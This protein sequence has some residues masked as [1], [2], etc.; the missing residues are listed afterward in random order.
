MIHIL[1]LE[2][3]PADAELIHARLEEEGI[4]FQSTRVDREAD[5]LGELNQDHYQVILSDYNV[6][7]ADPIGLLEQVRTQKP[8][9]PFIFV[10]GTIGEE[11]AVEVLR[12]GATDYVLKDNPTRLGTAVRRALVS[13]EE[14]VRRAQ[15]EAALRASEIRF[16]A[17]MDHNPSLTLIKDSAGR[18]LFSNGAHRKFMGIGEH[19]ILGRTIH[20]FFDAAT[21]ARIAEQDRWVFENNKVLETLMSVPDKDG[22]VR[23]LLTVKFPL[24]SSSGEPLLGGLLVDVTA[25]RSAEQ[26]IR[27][28]AGLLNEAHD[29]ICVCTTD[30]HIQYWNRS[31]SRIFGLPEDEALSQRLDAVLV[32]KVPAVLEQARHALLEQ[33]CWEGD[34]QTAHRDGTPVVVFSRWTLVRDEAGQP[35]SVLLINSDVTETRKLE[36]QF[37]RAQRVESIGLLASGIAHDLN[38]VLAPFMMIIPLLREQLTDPGFARVL[39]ALESSASRGSGLVQQ[40]L[41]FARGSDQERTLVQISHLIRELEK[42][43]RETFPRSIEVSRQLDKDLWVV[44]G[45]ASQLHQILLN[46]L[47]NARDAMPTGG[48]ITIQGHNQTL[49]DAQAREIPGASAGTYV[50]LTVTDSGTGIPPEV[51]P[52]IFDA[53]FTTKEQGRGTGL[54]LSTVA[55]IAKNHGGFLQVES[56]LGQGTTFRIFLPGLPDKRGQE[57]GGALD[58]ALPQGNNELILV[59]DDDDTIRQVMKSTLK[60]SGYR[61]AL[62]TNGAEAM[63]EYAAHREDVRLLVTD[64]N[65]PVMGGAALIQAL[66]YFDSKLPVL[67]MTGMDINEPAVR[68]SLSPGTRS[69][70]KPFTK[71]SLLHAIR[72]ALDAG[73]AGPQST[74]TS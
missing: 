36:E 7:G 2:D 68:G 27:E 73:K 55:T 62:A 4:Q 18:F 23:D 1:H 66:R 54:G 15:A 72:S 45:N 42:I 34:I 29:A 65:M 20:E 19:A 38:N 63:A 35:K 57:R 56:Q 28:Q 25:Q 67:V 22:R 26:K 48:R 47:V 53:F 10:T 24:T 30:F 3:N 43:T 46:L 58:A 51:L 74:T 70:R 9:L 40:I 5:F 14:Q 49:D 41:S 44:N 6:P 33:G 37:F 12:L 64:L 32:P 31:A 69:L 61:A 16:R 59:V 60:A 71:S 39:D 8:H 52:K 13:A 50:V 17:F 11:R 21:A